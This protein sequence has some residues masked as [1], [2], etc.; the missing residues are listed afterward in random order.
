MNQIVIYAE[1]YPTYV[2]EEYC[3]ICS[4]PYEATEITITFKDENISYN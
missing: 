2:W 3:D 1:D 4:V